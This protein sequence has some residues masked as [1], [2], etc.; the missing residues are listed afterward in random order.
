MLPADNP[1]LASVLICHGIGETAEQWSGV[2][3]LLAHRGVASLVFDYCGYGRSAG[4]FSAGRA[5]EDALSACGCLR[6]LT[7]AA[8][9]SLLGFS[10]GSGVAGA[11]VRQL[12]VHRLILCAAFSSLREAAIRG[13]LPAFL[14]WLVPNIWRTADTL[15]ESEIKVLV[16][17]ERDSLFPVAMAESLARAC[18]ERGRL[19]VAAGLTHDD[20]YHRPEA[21]YW[22]L[23][24]DEV[25]T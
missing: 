24:A 14:S 25:V 15:P 5:E 4:W 3:R 13:G 1:V 16:Q 8:P 19:V 7:P 18:G 20:P 2:Q 12:P 6:A 23:V 17:G 21:S 9:I 22:D 11:V 10:L